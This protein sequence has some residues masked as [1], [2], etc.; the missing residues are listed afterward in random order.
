MNQHPRILVVEDDD[1][2]R[3]AL[4]E[5]LRL[6][7]YE[8]ETAVDGED[9]LACIRSAPF[10]L[11]LSDVK[12]PRADG[13]ELVQRMRREPLGRDLPV[14]LFSA[15][16]DPDR[17]VRGLDLGADDYLAKP[18]ESTELLARVR[19]NLR[20]ADRSQE[21][22]QFAVIDELTGALNRRGIMEILEIEWKRSRRTGT[23][24]SALMIDIDRFKAVNDRFGH[25][26]GDAL[27]VH[28]TRALATA[29]RA[30]DRVGR[31]GGD[32]FLVLLPETRRTE[33]E[34]LAARLRVAAG[35][36]FSFPGGAS[37]R[38]R[39]S[40]GA[41][42][43]EPGNDADALVSRADAAMYRDKEAASLEVPGRPIHR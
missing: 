10:D 9:A 24:L 13:Y 38:L 39:L 22:R 28:V 15:L 41:A 34:L 4:A 7:G 20:R 19:A 14:I 31:I 18:V 37:V 11:V 12:M 26:A 30:H 17:R 6:E 36:R 35:D 33:A 25:A 1:V 43:L 23:P 8:V 29:V 42:S 2:S 40:V 21:L 16:S 3:S 27:L 32:E 5:L